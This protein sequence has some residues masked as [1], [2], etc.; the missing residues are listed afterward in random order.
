M[1]KLSELRKKA[2]VGFVARQA[3][4]RPWLS[5]SALSAPSD[6]RGF[7]KK[8]KRYAT[9]HF[10]PT[11]FEGQVGMPI[12]AALHK[13]A[14]PVPASQVAISGIGRGLLGALGAGIGA[15]AIGGL[16][17]GLSSLKSKYEAENAW[18]QVLQLHPEFR[19][20]FRARNQFELLAKFSPSLATNASLVADIVKRNLEF[21]VTP[22][23]F[24]KQIIDIE[25]GRT[26]PYREYITETA[27]GGIAEGL[28]SAFKSSYPSKK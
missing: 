4:K 10:Q 8:T 2:L 16:V 17:H 14:A 22:V 11:G 7:L 1:Q 24:I 21:E 13:R 20:N 25:K 19:N 23:E 27:K 12:T 15:V 9:K 3:L 26:A 6:A 18:K 28:Q 5:V